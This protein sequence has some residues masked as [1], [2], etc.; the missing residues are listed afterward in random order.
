MDFRGGMICKEEGLNQRKKPRE[1]G[2][3]EGESHPCCA[4]LSR[5][6]Q[7]GSGVRLCGLL[8]SPAIRCQLLAWAMS[9]THRGKGG[10]DR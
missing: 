10:E 8:A 4:A 2:K 3:S 7:L 9:L 5:L 1:R 6:S